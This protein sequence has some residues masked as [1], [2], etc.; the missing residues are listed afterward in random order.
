MRTKVWKET[1]DIAN[2]NLSRLAFHHVRSKIDHLLLN[3]YTFR[4]IIKG[5][6][7]ES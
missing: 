2:S 4:N 6:L 7:N 1:M 5:D 3:N